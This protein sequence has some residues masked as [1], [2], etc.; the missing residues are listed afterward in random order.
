MF[1]LLFQGSKYLED[2]QAEFIQTLK[3]S[4]V[5]LATAI[6]DYNP[7]GKDGC[8]PLQVSDRRVVNLSE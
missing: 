4:T 6:K 1:F 3:R 5:S 2:D 8:I 7:D